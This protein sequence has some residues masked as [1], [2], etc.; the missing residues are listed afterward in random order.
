MV[1][2]AKRFRD[3]AAAD[4]YATMIFRRYGFRASVFR[5]TSPRG[6]ISYEVIKPRNWG[7]IRL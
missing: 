3:K 6:D 1:Y 2:G 5:V 7:M 4:R